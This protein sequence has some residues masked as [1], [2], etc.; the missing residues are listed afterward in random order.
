VSI[1]EK[2]DEGASFSFTMSD[3]FDLKKQEFKFLDHPF[4]KEG[5]RITIKMGYANKM[6]TMMMG[7]ITSIESSF[8]AGETTTLA[9]GG[10]D[11]SYDYIKR[12]SA[13]RKFIDK[14]HSDIA[15]MIASEAGLLP[16]IDDTKEVVEHVFL[17]PS[18]KSY[19][20]LLTDFGKEVDRKFYMVGKTMYFVEPKDDEKEVVTLEFGKDIISF[21]PAM[22]TTGLLTEVEVR[23]HN[24][25]DPDKPIIGKATA[26]SERTQESGKK[27]GSQIAKEFC[28]NP[29]RIITDVIVKSQAEADKI[30]H[31]ELNKASDGLIEGEGE[32]IG[33]PEMRTGIN[34]ELKKIGKRFSGKYYVTGTTH[35][36]DSSGYRTRFS[37]KRNA[38]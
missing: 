4:F 12:P 37:A 32:C 28:K 18:D 13:E 5:N 9:I 6:F 34:V 1:E 31:A 10:Q 14:T 24:P 30:A 19:F 7:K 35:T 3:E 2:L 16:V 25:H 23:A 29:K 26:G 11:L 33:M 27:T 36:I 8:F 38:V 21:R 17:K 20:N 15:R 22:R